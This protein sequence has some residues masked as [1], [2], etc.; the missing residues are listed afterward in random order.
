LTDPRGPV[1]TRPVTIEVPTYSSSRGLPRLWPDEYSLKVEIH[2]GYVNIS[3]DPR[4]LRGLAAQLLALAEDEVPN[5]YADDLDDLGELDA[6][7]VQLTI[8]RC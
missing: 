7:S 1:V 4:G 3:G 5:G 6:G 2:G 8:I